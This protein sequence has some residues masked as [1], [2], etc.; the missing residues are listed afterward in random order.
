MGTGGNLLVD[1]TVVAKPSARLLSNVAWVWSS[2]AR[3][4]VFGVSV[5]RLG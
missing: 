1:D 3:Q 2:Q 4:V 5:V